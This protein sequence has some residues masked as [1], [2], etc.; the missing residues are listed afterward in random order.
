M[1]HMNQEPIGFRVDKYGYKEPYYRPY[2]KHWYERPGTGI[3][4]KMYNKMI[5]RAYE[6]MMCGHVENGVRYASTAC[7]VVCD[8]VKSCPIAFESEIQVEEHE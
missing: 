5:E 2:P 7:M 4:G 1:G 8:W 3:H 6:A